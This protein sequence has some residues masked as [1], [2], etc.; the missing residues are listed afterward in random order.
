MLVNLTPHAVTLYPERG[1]PIEI[2][3]S[4]QVARLDEHTTPT[5]S[6]DG[7]GVDIPI[8][9]VEMRS[10]G[11]MPAPQPGVVYV[12]SRMV[13]QGYPERADLLFPL[14]PVRDGQGRIVGCRALGT[15]CA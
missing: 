15:V 12:V 13:A 2:P 6:P 7:L 10:S 5:P 14:D 4:G 1:E 8:R 3:P 9:L 11:H